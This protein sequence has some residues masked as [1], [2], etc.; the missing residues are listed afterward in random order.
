M[1]K[2]VFIG[3]V[4]TIALLLGAPYLSGKIAETQTL[5][6]VDAIIR[7]P[8][9]YG[10]LDVVS[11]HR[12]FAS[13]CAKYAYTPPLLLAKILQSNDAIEYSCDSQH[14]VW[15]VDFACQLERAGA[16]TEFVEQQL[17]GVDP[18]SMHG[19]LSAFGKITQTLEFDA[20]ANLD[21]DG[22][23]VS[24]PRAIMTIET[25]QSMSA[26]AFDGQVDAFEVENENRRFSLGE[27]SF[28][29]DVEAIADVFIVGDFAMSLDTFS[30]KNAGNEV[31]LVDLS[32]YSKS[33]E[34]GDNID[35]YSI[36]KIASLETSDAAVADV[37]DFSLT[38]ELNG[39]DTAALI[40]Y[41]AL[42]MQLQREWLATLESSNV[43]NSDQ[44]TLLQ[45][46]PIIESMLKPGLE[47]KIAAQAKLD[48]TDNS[49]ALSSRLLEPL[50]LAQMPLFL[51]DPESA[52]QKLDSHI[53]ASLSKSFV[54]LQPIVAGIIAHSP[55]IEVSADHYQLTLTIGNEIELNGQV[56]SLEALQSLVLGNASM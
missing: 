42:S 47:I 43:A 55:L 22:Q 52:L 28:T 46:L 14:G 21:V 51:A 18:L 48:G 13:S 19:S 26:L 24:T 49:V 6:W 54:D 50:T 39:L 3:I 7:E 36:V 53:D 10:D 4:L 34:N 44:N 33:L 40:E 8:K 16:Y 56:I 32:V 35:S 9:L 1:K 29:G 5:K 20:I 41:Q 45:M 23:S 15:G 27:I 25:N 11:Y 37:E 30:L 31:V 12:E 17:A 2:S 38:T